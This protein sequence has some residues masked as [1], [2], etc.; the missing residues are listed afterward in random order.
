MIIFLYGPNTYFLHQ[1]L[2]Q[3]KKKA[4]E[5]VFVDNFAEFQQ[6]TETRSLFNVKRV[7]IINKLSP[8]FEKIEDSEDIIVFCDEKPDKRTKLFKKLLKIA[9]CQEFNFLK[10][11]ELINWI[12]KQANISFSAAQKLSVFFDKNLWQ[13]KNEL[14]KL[15]AYVNYHNQISDSDIKQLVKA[16]FSADIFKTIDALAQGN[17]KTALK[18]VY[19]HL[20]SGDDENYLFNMFCYQFRNILNI[21]L[22]NISNMHPFVF[23]KTKAA[24]QEYSLKKLQTIYSQLLCLDL[25]AKTSRVSQP[26]TFFLLLSEV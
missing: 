11:H 25:W 17:K 8:E 22:N 10:N 21:K 4:K 3:I 18:L 19:E 12:K 23:L 24:A 6:A 7:I 2:K 1:K 9:Q 26:A 20:A 13:L 5:L 16:K 15:E 14:N